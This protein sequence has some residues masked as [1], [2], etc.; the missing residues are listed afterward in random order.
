MAGSIMV[1]GVDYWING[2]TKETKNGDKYISLSV[3]LKEAKKENQVQSVYD[4][5]RKT[6]P[7]STHNVGLDDDIPF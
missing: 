7:V 2:W 1:N 3:S 5:Q 4:D 6:E